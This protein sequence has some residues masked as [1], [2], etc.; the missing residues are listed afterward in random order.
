METK[1]VYQV[2]NA[3]LI[4]S[5]F[6]EQRL[7]LVLKKRYPELNFSNGMF[8]PIVN[9]LSAGAQSII[10]E[11]VNEYGE[12]ALEGDTDSIPLVEVS[13]SEDKGKVLCAVSGF[14]YSQREID[15]V[16]L[17]RSNGQRSADLEMQVERGEVLRY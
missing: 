3:G 12:A 2:D 7:P 1:V 8:L 5:R 16:D 17:A 4:M 14:R 6:L 11:V 13:A 9:D 10:V 15:A